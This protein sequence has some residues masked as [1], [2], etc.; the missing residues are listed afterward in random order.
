V[1]P[2]SSHYLARRRAEDALELRSLAYSWQEVADKLGYRSRQAAH[3]AV[4]R[5]LASTRLADLEGEARERELDIRTSWV[6]SP[7]PSPV[8]AN[9]CWSEP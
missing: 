1:A 9:K 2:V 8:S 3:I 7:S 5:L 6:K 4:S